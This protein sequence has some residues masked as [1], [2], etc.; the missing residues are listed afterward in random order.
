MIDALVEFIYLIKEFIL[1]IVDGLINFIGVLMAVW[2]MFLFNDIGD[3]S[4]TLYFP[5]AVMN[6]VGLCAAIGIVLRVFG[7]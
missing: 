1:G 3:G 5:S 4:L 2:D 7:R 6:I